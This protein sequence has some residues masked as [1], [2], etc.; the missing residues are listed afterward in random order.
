N[1]TLT[2]DDDV[3]HG[4]AI[5]GIIAAKDNSFGLVGIAPDTEIYSVKVLN[6]EAKGSLD[7]LVKGIEWCIDNNIQVINLSF[8]LTEDK[9]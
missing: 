1:M 8:G 4:T 7:T 2:S 6:S 3:G 5:A 9:P